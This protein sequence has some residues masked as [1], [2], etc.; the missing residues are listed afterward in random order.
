[1]DNVSKLKRSSIMKAIKS[2]GTNLENMMS[3][4]LFRM[5]YRFRRNVKSLYGKPDI[6]IKKYKIVIFIDS[7]FWHGCPSHCRMPKTNRMYWEN[8]IQNNINRDNKVTFYYKKE[9]WNIMRIWEHEIEENK[10]KSI[11]K[12]ANFVSEHKNK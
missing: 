6:A 7:C 2:D 8:K 10:E 1:M 12:V 3:S 11:Y 4:A 5:G 9:G